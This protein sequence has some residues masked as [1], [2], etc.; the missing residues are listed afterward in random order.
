[1]TIILTSDELE[2]AEDGSERTVL[3]QHSALETQS[4]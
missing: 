3:I 4:P 2:R 1:M